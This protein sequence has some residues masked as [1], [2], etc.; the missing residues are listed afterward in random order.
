MRIKLFSG[1]SPSSHHHQMPGLTMWVN[2][3]LITCITK[4]PKITESAYNP[5]LFGLLHQ[6]LSL[7]IDL[8]DCI[9]RSNYIQSLCNLNNILVTSTCATKLGLVI[10]KKKLPRSYSYLLFHQLLSLFFSLTLSNIYLTI[11][12]YCSICKCVMLSDWH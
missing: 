7:F 8:F 12:E 9:I 6:L 2:M 11:F 10:G 1:Y 4:N 5:F 3:L